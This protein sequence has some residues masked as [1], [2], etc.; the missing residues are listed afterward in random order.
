MSDE[1]EITVSN[2]ATYVFCPRKLWLTSNGHDPHDVNVVRGATEHDAVDNSSKPM[3]VHDP[4]IGLHGTCD[5]VSIDENIANITEYKSSSSDIPVIREHVIVQLAAYRH[6]L[7]AQGYVVRSAAVWWTTH[8][9]ASTVSDFAMDVFNVPE[10]TQ[11]CRGVMA[12]DT[13]PPVLEDDPRCAGCSLVEACQPSEELVSNPRIVPSRRDDSILIVDADVRRVSTSK[14]HIKLDGKD[15]GKTL[16]APIGQVSGMVVLNTHAIITTQAILALIEDGK[17]VVYGWGKPQAFTSPV[18]LPNGHSR[19]RL[20][21]ADSSI[22][23]YLAS[24]NIHAKVHN[25]ASRVRALDPSA[26]RA[27]RGLR[28]DVT[29]IDPNLPEDEYTSKLFGLEG[30]SA[31]LYFSVVISSLPT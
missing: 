12:S 19:A 30:G 5:S 29:S 6:C 24:K 21:A 28:D 4:A 14:G 2:V 13:S 10:L 15:G 9:Y 11:K 3:S 8:G 22:R 17:Y 27:I 25:Q 18:K 26:A 31:T 1:R 16:S 23:K 20:A 7:T